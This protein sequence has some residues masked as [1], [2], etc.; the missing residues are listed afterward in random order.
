MNLI[1]QEAHSAA[2][3]LSKAGNRL[4]GD[5]TGRTITKTTMEGSGSL[6]LN[7]YQAHTLMFIALGGM[8]SKNKTLRML[9]VIV[10]VALV[11]MYLAGRGLF[12]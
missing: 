7:G 2:T 9:G 12:K 4:L 3:E 6:N 1:Y 10:L 8:I 11:F 5:K